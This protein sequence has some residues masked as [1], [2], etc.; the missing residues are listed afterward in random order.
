LK[1]LFMGTPD[2]ASC[3]LEA[4]IKSK[5]EVVCVVT[6]EDKPKGRGKEI[7]MSPVKEVALEHGIEVFQPHILKSEE[8]V[9]KLKTYDADI[10]VV[11]A[12][13]KILSKEILDIPKYGCINIH[14]SLLP[15]YRGA[16]PIQWVIIDGEKLTGVTIMQ[17]NE[18]LDTG[19]M[20]FKSVVEIAD[21]D[22]AES[23]FDKLSQSGASL[24]VEALDRIEEGDI[25]P[26]PQDDSLATYAKILT[27][28]SGHINYNRSAYDIERLIRGL[29][30]WPGT[31]SYINGKMIKI[32]KAVVTDIPTEKNTPG[33]VIE[34]EGGK[35]FIATADYA[36]ELL[37]I[38]LEGKKRM[39]V[40]DF[41][42]GYEIKE[43][44][45]FE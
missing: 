33:S 27:K 23:L 40:S 20:L 4:I 45:C 35:L 13:G 19:D 5:H 12:Y 14:A 43:S 3:V 32:Y 34:C 7:A 37:E 16:A 29:Y 2:I 28:A 22:T 24:A 18:G 38:Q 30:P 11:I 42:R 41:L 9:A 1:V 21:D 39:N 8:S 17:M 10:Y 25:H 26:T 31:Y 6:G 15:K 36:L 44:D